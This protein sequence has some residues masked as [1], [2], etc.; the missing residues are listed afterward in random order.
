MFRTKT[1][2]LFSRILSLHLFINSI[3]L[4]PF[5]RRCFFFVGHVK[6]TIRPRLYLVTINSTAIK[7]KKITT[8]QLVGSCDVWSVFVC[9]RAQQQYQQRAH[10]IGKRAQRRIYIVYT[11]DFVTFVSI[12]FLSTWLKYIYFLFLLD[13]A[14]FVVGARSLFDWSP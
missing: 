3:Q 13:G 12:R 1:I 2:S 10:K 8:I 7:N 5:L 6:V 11:I 14:F 4:D 9:N